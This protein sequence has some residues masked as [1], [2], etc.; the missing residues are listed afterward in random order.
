[1]RL[2]YNNYFN[3]AAS[4][5]KQ[6][7]NES[8]GLLNKK[9]LL[10]KLDKRERKLIY[11]KRFI[12]T[13]TIPPIVFGGKENFIKRCKNLISHEEWVKLRDNRIYSRGDKTK[14]GNPNLRIIIKD[15]MTYLEVS[16]LNRDKNNRA[17]KVQM[18]I[19][20][21]QKLSKKTGK[22]NGINYRQLFINY[23]QT[24]KAY[25]VE[26]IRRNDRYYVHI[27]FEAEAMER[28]YTSNEKV[29]GVDTNPDGFAVTIVDR[30]GNY[31]G[32]TYLKEHELLY[33][34]GN[35]RANLCG[36]LVKRLTSLAAKENCAIALE[37]L[38]FKDDKY[39]KAKLNR[40]THQF[41]YSALLNM[42]EVACGREGIE[43]IKVK[44]Q[45]TSKIGLYKYCHQYGLYVHNGAALVI[46]RRSYGYK[47]KVPK[48]LVDKFIIDKESFN[49]C[50]EWKKWSLIH[51]SIKNKVKEVKHLSFWITNRNKLLGISM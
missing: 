50:N 47:E 26:I 34:R 3:K 5:K 14:K 6:L 31:K 10:S 28:V 39:T 8:L 13:N 4:I 12:D 18:P 17:V 27:T 7:E 20:L 46:G 51:K 25:Q 40:S 42:L 21:H 45:Y 49:K 24:G 22:V 30:T 41:I 9:A 11:F 2:N 23:L 36:E 35:R 38:R 37:D 19:Y 15:N 43:F 44:P 48:M 29:L 33:A 1:M 32:S 16:T